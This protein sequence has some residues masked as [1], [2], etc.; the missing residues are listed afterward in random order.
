MTEPMV[1]CRRVGKEYATR[2]GTIAALADI[3]FRVG[4]GEFVCLVGPSGCGKSTVLKL[5][6]G[7][8]Q[9][10]SGEVRVAEAGGAHPRCALVFQEHGLFPW[11]TIEDNVAF[12]LE[13]Q[14]L[15]KAVGRER[16]AVFLGEMGLGRFTRNYPHELSV[17]M[18]Q[19]AGIA[20]AFLSESPLLLMDEPFSALDAQS[21]LVLQQELLRIWKD[22]RRTVLYVTHDIEEAVLLG[23]RVLVLSGRPSRVQ[24]EISVPLARPRDLHDR[25]RPQVREIAW[26]IWQKIEAD[27][28]SNLDLTGASAVAN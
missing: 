27:V 14:H 19:R 7:L 26:R 6:A 17:G 9:P 16:A 3:S 12:G 1:E 18:R 15:P 4:A 20:R 13:L 24:D 25:E 2:Q 5:V 21:K 11:M 28:Q 22:H 23:D 10:T 8:I